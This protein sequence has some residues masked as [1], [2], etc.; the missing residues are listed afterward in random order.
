M[1]AAQTPVGLLVVLGACANE[2][3]WPDNERL[4]EARAAMAADRGDGA[5]VIGKHQHKTPAGDGDGRDAWIAG[6]MQGANEYRKGLSD[7]LD[8]DELRADAVL[9]QQHYAADRGAA[10]EDAPTM[11]D[12]I[13]AVDGSLHA[14]IVY[15]QERATKA[16]AK[17]TP[18]GGE[19]GRRLDWLAHHGA[20][21]RCDYR[22]LCEPWFLVGAYH[23]GIACVDDRKRFAT[24]REA[25][26]AAMAAV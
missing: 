15:W 8:Q 18:A 4:A 16:E 23:T 20:S 12:A 2:L 3:V 26:D 19:D 10:R 6:Y 17:L 14:A 24:A 1:T 13:A 9:S 11:E 7:A 25:I 5:V 21:I 22:A